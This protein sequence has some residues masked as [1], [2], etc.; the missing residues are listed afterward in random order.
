VTVC[1]LAITWRDQ[2]RGSAGVANTDFI[3]RFDLDLKEKI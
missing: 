2:G 1:L 3:G